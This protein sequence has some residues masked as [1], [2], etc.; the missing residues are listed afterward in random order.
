MET[1][2]QD[3]VKMHDIESL[4]EVMT[5]NDDFMYCLDA[6]EGLV[7]LDDPRGLE[8][9][10][11]ATLSEDEDI[12]VVAQEILD[13]PDVRRKRENL[14]VDNKRE[15]EDYIAG[16]KKR[17]QAGKKVFVYKTVYL[18]S[19]FFLSDESSEDG[20]NVPALND[21]GFDGWEVTAFVGRVG[22]TSPILSNGNVSGGYFIMKKELTPDEIA[23]LDQL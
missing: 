15:R 19:S 21:F 1:A 11:E 18:S 6:A 17:L 4:Y 12:R 14:E 5:E 23:E 3:L 7:M 10:N 16:A 8:F 20:D 9:L 22:R 2:I 13:S